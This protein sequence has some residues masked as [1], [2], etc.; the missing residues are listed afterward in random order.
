MVVLLYL[1]GE[2]AGS[3]NYL[4]LIFLCDC[5]VC[6]RVQVLTR[7]VPGQGGDGGEGL[8]HRAKREVLHL[9]R[10]EDAQTG[11]QL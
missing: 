6:C 10:A 3:Q 1:F 11:V 4:N 7:D 8:S 5:S 9:L 2:T